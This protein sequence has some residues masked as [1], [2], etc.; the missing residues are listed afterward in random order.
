MLTRRSTTPVTRKA[1]FPI[2]VNP[3]SLFAEAAPF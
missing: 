1:P 2:L 3:I